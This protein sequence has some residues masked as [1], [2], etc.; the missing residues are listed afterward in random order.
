M[1]A[2]P[3]STLRTAPWILAAR[4]PARKTTASATSPG[5]LIRR[6]GSMAW[7]EAGL[8]TPLAEARVQKDLEQAR[9]LGIENSPLVRQKDY[10]A[11]GIAIARA[12]PS[13]M[14]AMAWVLY[15][16]RRSRRFR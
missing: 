14:L 10:V 13:R 11:G 12:M 16:G 4:G 7:I 15:S 8:R 2:Q 9:R 5:V 1:A 3:P 6:E